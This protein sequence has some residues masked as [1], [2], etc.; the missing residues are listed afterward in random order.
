MKMKNVFGR[1][2]TVMFA[3]AVVLCSCGKDDDPVTPEVPVVP[4]EPEKPTDV[5]PVITDANYVFSSEAGAYTLE[6]A[7]NVNWN[8]VSSND[9]L[10][11]DKTSGTDKVELAVTVDENTTGAE[12]KGTITITNTADNKVIFTFGVTQAAVSYVLNVTGN[13]AE[14]PATGGFIVLEVEANK[15]YV[16]EMEEWVAEMLVETNMTYGTAKSSLK[17]YIGANPLTVD[18]TSKVMIKDGEEVKKTVN[19]RQLASEAPVIEEPVVL[20]DTLFVNLEDAADGVLQIPA[21]GGVIT[22]ISH[23]NR[24][25]D[26]LLTPWMKKQQ[27]T[28]AVYSGDIHTTTLYLA[29]DANMTSMARQATL[30][31]E[32]QGHKSLNRDFTIIQEPVAIE[33]ELENGAIALP[34]K[35]NVSTS[36]IITMPKKLQLDVIAITELMPGKVDKDE[37][38]K[39]KNVY[40]VDV[41]SLYANTTPNTQTRLMA[42]RLKT[43]EGGKYD[44]NVMIKQFGVPELLVDQSG[45][46]SILPAQGV[47][48]FELKVSIKVADEGE[49][50]EGLDYLVETKETWIH[51]EKSLTDPMGVVVAVDDN[52]EYKERE[53]K[54]I[55]SFDD[56]EYTLTREVYISQ[57]AKEMEYEL[58]VNDQRITE[59]SAI[60]CE[61]MASKR[62]LPAAEN[63]DVLYYVKMEVVG[64]PVYF[65]STSG[66]EDA[67]TK[68]VEFFVQ[69]NTTPEERVETLVAKIMKRTISGGAEEVI[70]TTPEFKVTQ[71]GKPAVQKITASVKGGNTTLNPEGQAPVQLEVSGADAY[72]I[73]IVNGGRAYDQYLKYD[74]IPNDYGVIN[75]WQAKPGPPPSLIYVL[76]AGEEWKAENVENYGKIEG[77]SW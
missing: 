42:L 68:V 66:I 46:G 55:F 14:I 37:T 21:E 70:Y 49:V 73:V 5:L 76:P 51:V 23:A 43:E 26:V 60:S 47:E 31:F 56:S 77:L 74:P 54:I 39:D 69:P 33:V 7:A 41:K 64:E 28:N 18:R 57:K 61:L 32:C 19:L 59:Y 38:V 17:F 9:W 45:M 15:D 3:A 35:A 71:P 67:S 53:G 27:V 65:S 2:V 1:I 6:V 62:K 34:A 12:R 29:I 52:S 58:V 4:E 44:W 48:N 30:A 72:Q 75:V 36:L 20:P 22:A 11:I 40:K 13:D 63:E 8:A 25:Y 10:K 16:L 50:P 24:N